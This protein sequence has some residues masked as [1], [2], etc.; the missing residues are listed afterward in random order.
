M[1][2]IISIVIKPAEV[3]AAGQEETFLRVPV[4]EATLVRGHGVAGDQK[5]GHHPDRQVNILSL[6]W[7][8]ALGAQG[9][10]TAPGSFGEQLIVG[11][12][13]NQAL[14]PGARLSI[15]EQAVVELTKSRTGCERL[16]AAQQR[17]PLAG[18]AIGMLARVLKGGK[19]RVGDRVEIKTP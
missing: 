8:E 4:H 13:D 5:G 3:S 15:G 10:R 6:D 1:A 7:V 12:L 19:I 17:R 16:E 14:L 2:E 11:G 9:Y 18:E